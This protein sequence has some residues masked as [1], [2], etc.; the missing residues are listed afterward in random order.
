MCQITGHGV[1]GSSIR[2]NGLSE[3]RASWRLGAWGNAVIRPSG[4]CSCGLRPLLLDERMYPVPMATTDRGCLAGS[5]NFVCR[6]NALTKCR[7][8]ATT[9]HHVQIDEWWYLTAARI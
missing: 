8:L 4:T 5:V 7:E 6:A 9:V 2:G 1:E 3:Y